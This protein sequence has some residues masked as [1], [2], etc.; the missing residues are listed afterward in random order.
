MDKQSP[1]YQEN[2]IRSARYNLLVAIIFTVLNLVMLL[3]GS[4]R[5]FLFSTSIPYYLTYFGYLFDHYTVGGYTLTGLT[6]AAVFVA[7]YAVFW[8]MSKK[9]SGWFIAALVLFGVDTLAMLLLML[10][11][12]DIGSWLFEI[13]FHVWVIISLSRGIAAAAKL[14]NMPQ[15]PEPPQYTMYTG[16][17]MDA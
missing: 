10:L 5:Y 3:V 12:G 4:N 7:A 13:V 8:F 6:M 1:E 2:L 17:E 15:I 14:K 11:F 16:P 9:H